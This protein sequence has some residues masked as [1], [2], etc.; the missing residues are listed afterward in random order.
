MHKKRQ[1]ARLAPEYDRDEC[2]VYV[3]LL[4]VAGRPT[5]PYV[6]HLTSRR[7]NRLFGA[8]TWIVYVEGDD[9]LTRAYGPDGLD[10]RER[11]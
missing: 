3:G 5:V 1:I 10:A 2:H 8:G 4:H 11:P 7:L 9:G 6:G